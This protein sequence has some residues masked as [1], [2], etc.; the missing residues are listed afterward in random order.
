[1]TGNCIKPDDAMVGV[2]YMLV[3]RQAFVGRSKI[4][5]L[6]YS[7]SFARGIGLDD[8]RSFG[9]G[10][11]RV[12]NVTNVYPSPRCARP[13]WHQVKRIFSK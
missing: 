3:Q 7:G 8:G 9:K 12:R 1:M 5:F 11:S 4:N 6:K 10:V 13:H 2:R